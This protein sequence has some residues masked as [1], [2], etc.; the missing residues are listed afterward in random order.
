VSTHPLYI[1]LL[2]NEKIVFKLTI[3]CFN[4]MKESRSVVIRLSPMQ[5]H[6]NP[7]SERLSVVLD[8]P[9][10]QLA[11]RMRAYIWVSCMKNITLLARERRLVASLIRRI[12]MYSNMAS[13]IAN[14][15]TGLRQFI[16]PKVNRWLSL[17]FYRKR[18]EY[19]K[20]HSEHFNVCMHHSS[21]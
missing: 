7:P 11:M 12:I 5:G 4:I 21:V 18:N 3:I 6:F 8:E 16:K 15:F 13:F 9:T 19:V 17:V 14:Y 10:T 1:P 20:K 2:E